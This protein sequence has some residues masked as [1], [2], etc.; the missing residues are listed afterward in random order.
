MPCLHSRKILV[1]AL[2]A[3]CSASCAR[4]A[5][6]TIAELIRE[7]RAEA[8]S[9][10]ASLAELKSSIGS[11]QAPSEVVFESFDQ[12]RGRVA[13]RAKIS[14]R[15]VSYTL[16]ENLVDP[17]K[18]AVEIA[19]PANGPLSKSAAKAPVAPTIE[20]SIRQ[21]VVIATGH[22]FD[23]PQNYPTGY[24]AW[25]R[26]VRDIPTKG[27]EWVLTLQGTAGPV[28]EVYLG[29][30]RYFIAWVCEPHNCGG[31]EAIVL[32]KRDQS[33]V[34][35][36]VDLT[37]EDGTIDTFYVGSPSESEI[38]CIR[39]FSEAGSNLGFCQ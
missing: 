37:A 22:G 7:G 3:L 9:H 2:V 10:P 34:I 8:C 26:L 28:R 23:V 30:E 24:A 21:P 39:R 25:R 5:P 18:V 35:G 15:A 16:A 32:I 1:A 6:K 38:E 13:C 33:R 29:I 19:A 14:G 20:D 27:R 31:N 4:E 12:E 36:V 11:A 17:A